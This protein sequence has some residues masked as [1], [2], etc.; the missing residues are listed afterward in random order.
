MIQIAISQ[1]AFDAIAA[2][3]PFGTMNYE[4]QPN[5]NGERLIWLEERWFDKLNSIRRS[6]ETTR[7]PSSGS[8]RCGKDIGHTSDAEQTQSHARRRRE[9]QRRDPA[10]GRGRTRR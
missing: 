3:M 6:G 9:L 4:P 8:L 1:A 5:E 7:T 10:A 2:T